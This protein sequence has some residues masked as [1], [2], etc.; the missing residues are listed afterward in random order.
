MK[1]V[2]ALVLVG[3][4]AFL[5]VLAP[6]AK[7]YV[8]PQLAVAP[9]GCDP[10]PL[11]EGGVSIS[12]SSGVARV[13][14]DPATLSPRSDVAL[15]STRR[16]KPDQA[17]SEGPN[18]QTVYDS[19]Q[20]VTDPDG[21]TVDASTERIAFNGHTSAMIN[22]CG[23]NVDGTPITDFSG[24]APYKFPFGTEKQTYQ[25]FDG[26]LSKALPME[27]ET[28]EEI[29]G[30]EV[31]KFVQ[32]IEPTL[33][34]ELEVPGGLVGQPDS[35]SIVAPRF[36]TNV[37]TVWVEPVTGAIVKGQEV[38]KQFLA[39]ADG[40][41][42]ALVIIDATLQFTP[43]NTAEAVKTASDGKSQLTLIQTTVPLV[44]FILGLL[45]LAGG[46]F[47]SLRGAARKPEQD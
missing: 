39:G 25:Y 42:E 41:T 38:Q 15:L 30:L 46:L 5:L 34:A 18:N 8:A 20:D 21:V 9:L 27:Y 24:I 19:F 4:G 33:Y 29:L 16:V 40:T 23:A 1:K 32:T 36:Y 44:A 31:Y 2:I 10:G 7:W 13:L 17:A 12:P 14:F 3:L 43:E 11:C 22:C 6:L 35:A 45:A 28:T 47:L 26:T 37:R